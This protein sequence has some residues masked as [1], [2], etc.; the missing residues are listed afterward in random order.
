MRKRKTEPY[1]NHLSLLHAFQICRMILC[2]KP[3]ILEF[4]PQI[5]IQYSSCKLNLATSLFAPATYYSRF[6]SMIPGGGTFEG[7]DESILSTQNMHVYDYTSIAKFNKMFNNKFS[8]LSQNVRSLARNGEKLKELVTRTHP[9]VVGLQEIWKGDLSVD[10]YKTIFKERD[11]RG[12]GVGFLVAEEYQFNLIKSNIDFN[13][14]FIIIEIESSFYISTYIPHRGNAE[15]DLKTLTQEIRNL[16]KKEIFLMGDFN[17]DLL[18]EDFLAN[19]FH[20]FM[21][22]LNLY[23]TI[24]RPTRTK[25]LSLLD[26]IL[27]NTSKQIATGILPTSI[28]DHMTIYV[29]T[30]RQKCTHKTIIKKHIYSHENVGNLKTLMKYENCDDLE[31]LPSEQKCNKFNEIFMGN[32]NLCCPEIEFERRKDKTKLEKWFPNGLL[33]SRKKKEKYL[34]KLAKKANP[35]Y[36]WKYYTDYVNLYY[37]VVRVAKAKYWQA[38]F[39]EN[40]TNMKVIWQETNKALGRGNKS[41]SFPKTFIVN[42]TEIQ[43][44]ENLANAFNDFFVSVGTSLA[45]KFELT[46]NFKQYVKPSDAGFQ[47]L[48]GE[49][50]KTIYPK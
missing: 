36:N 1:F 12:G 49:S 4:T 45:D 19:K 46:D 22:D 32:L 8:I 15:A 48:S 5:K 6:F 13:L 24:G 10:G 31:D 27:T 33:V 42:G 34:K 50:A 25:S 35:S 18:K 39:E 21:Q 3:Q 11:S 16:S 2:R 43:G 23:P 40:Y 41:Q 38:F 28:S 20:A 7:L 14:E 44:D 9:S 37:K 26:N 30:D 47:F 29:T 17:I